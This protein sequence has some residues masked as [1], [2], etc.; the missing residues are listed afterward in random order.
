VTADI[1]NSFLE[2]NILDTD[3]EIYRRLQQHLDKGPVGYPATGSGVDI[4]LLKQL[5]TPA[6]AQIA[7]QLSTIKLEPAKIIYHRAKKNGLVKSLDELQQTLDRMAYKGTIL[8][9]SLGL[10]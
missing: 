6:E 4:S 10:K 3:T 9:Y 7:A 8:V 2:E 1:T 5:L